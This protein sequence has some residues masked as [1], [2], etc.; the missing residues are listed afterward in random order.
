MMHEHGRVQSETV[1]EGETAV[2]TP[3]MAEETTAFEG[4]HNF[5]T[6]EVD[7]VEISPDNEDLSPLSANNMGFYQFDS[8]ESDLLIAF[9]NG[10]TR[11]GLPEGWI[12][13]SGREQ[14]SSN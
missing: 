1:H 4:E 5:N 3:I 9:A 13:V 11:F 2:R 8:F 14:T 7:L 6:Q 12:E 10:D